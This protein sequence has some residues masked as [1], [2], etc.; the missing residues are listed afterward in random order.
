MGY[1]VRP[2]I[3]FPVPLPPTPSYY[4]FKL[5]VFYLQNG[6]NVSYHMTR[7]DDEATVFGKPLPYNEHS[8][9]IA[10]SSDDSRIEQ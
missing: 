7:G 8:A 2:E 3:Q 4:L 10:N 1:G 6:D 9:M 5:Q